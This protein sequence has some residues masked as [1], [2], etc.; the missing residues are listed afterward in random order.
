MSNLTRP[1]AAQS[2]LSHC[3]TL[4][5]AMRAHSTGHTSATGRSQSTMPPEWMPR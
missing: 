1:A 5:S 4:R 2:S 3:R